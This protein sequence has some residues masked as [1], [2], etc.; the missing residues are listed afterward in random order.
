MGTARIK[1]IINNLCTRKLRSMEHGHI[2]IHMCSS[3]IGL[4][5]SFLFSSLWGR[6]YYRNSREGLCI[7]FSALVHYFLLVYFC[8]TVSQSVLLYLK[9]IKVLGTQQYLNQ[10]NLKVGLV[11]WGKFPDANLNMYV[12]R[13]VV[14]D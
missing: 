5:L 7:T 8:I 12:C 2:L 14:M 6:F 11:S 3:L 1:A 13:T 10:F 9:L 4:Y